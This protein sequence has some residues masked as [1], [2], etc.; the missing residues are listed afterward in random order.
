VLEKHDVSS[1]KLMFVIKGLWIEIQSQN[2]QAFNA[3]MR[4]VRVCV[5]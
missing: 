3:V 4:G 5:C 2:T 1:N